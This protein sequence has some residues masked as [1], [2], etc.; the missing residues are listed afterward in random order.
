MEL[1]GLDVDVAGEDVVEDDVLDEGALVVLFIVEVL[2]VGKSNGKDGRYLLRKLVLALDEYYVLPFGACTDRSVGISF[3]RDGFGC[4]GKLIADALPHFSDFNQLT[5]SYDD[6]VFVN[7]TDNTV[8]CISHLVDDSL[9]QTI[10]HYN[11]H[12]PAAVRI[13]YILYY[14]LHDFLSFFNREIRFFY[15]KRHIFLL[16]IANLYKVSLT[17]EEKWKNNS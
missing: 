12:Q 4:I 7:Y 16:I 6:P 1:L 10:C 8:D 2:Y 17:L 11:L 5:A 9:E 3:R 14:I 15:K 13:L